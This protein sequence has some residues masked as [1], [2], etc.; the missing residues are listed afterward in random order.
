[1]LYPACVSH[2]ILASPVGVPNEPKVVKS[3]RRNRLSL[4]W[5]LARGLVQF[6]WYQGCTPQTI[7]RAIGPIGP[8]PVRA[9]VTRRFL[10]GPATQESTLSTSQTD[11]D[12]STSG[13]HQINTNQLK[14]PKEEL[15]DY[16]VSE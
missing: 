7:V 14:L 13:I 8:R 12:I 9:Y 4:G 11:R 6:L 5:R 16:L 1:M 3:P 2:L 15:A 10:V